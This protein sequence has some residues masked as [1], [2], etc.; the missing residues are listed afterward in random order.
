MNINEEEDIL[1]KRTVCFSGHRP[2]KLP[3]KG[4][5]GATVIRYLKSILYKEIL[6]SITAGYDRFITGL[7]RG[8]DLWAG[9]IL[10]ELKAQGENLSI[11]AVKPYKSHGDNFSGMDK[12]SLGRLLS[13][14]DDVV[15]LA[16]EYRK[17]C[18][19]RRNEYMVDRSGKLIAVVSDYRSGTGAT[20]RYAEKQGIDVRVIDAGIFE[21]QIN[22]IEDSNISALL[23]SPADEYEDKLAF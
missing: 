19:Q 1:R 6:D 16:D 3:L 7:A 22:A 4:D 9:E 14:A 17:G 15:C 8:V 20:I 23:Y 5:S 13:R 2:E 21:E 18:L 10:M 12:F 11:I